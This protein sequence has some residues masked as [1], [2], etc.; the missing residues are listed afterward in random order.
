MKVISVLNKVCAV[1]LIALLCST[2]LIVFGYLTDN[3]VAGVKVGYLLG[4]GI[5]GL[6]DDK[7]VLV[8]CLY[9]PCTVFLIKRIIEIIRSHKKNSCHWLL[10][11]Y[12]SAELLL[13][14]SHFFVQKR[15]PDSTSI[16]VNSTQF[17]LPSVSLICLCWILLFVINLYGYLRQHNSSH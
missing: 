2:W 17:T 7:P 16:Q 3:V 1:M 11:A 14:S 9:L 5:A 12:L 10:H 8:L 15:F 4:I 13:F 6:W